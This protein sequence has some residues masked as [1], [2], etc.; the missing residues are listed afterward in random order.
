MVAP[1]K[2]V[3]LSCGIELG[4]QEGA[5]GTPAKNA[6]I[7][8]HRAHRDHRVCHEPPRREGRKWA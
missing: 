2:C 1:V 6:K 4:K 5:A 7:V 8:S 3:S